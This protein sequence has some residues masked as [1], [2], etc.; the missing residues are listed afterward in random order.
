MSVIIC[1]GILFLAS[2]QHNMHASDQHKTGKPVGLSALSH[3]GKLLPMRRFQNAG[4]PDI[5]LRML[6]GA[7]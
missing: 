1:V 5:H 6:R 4:L 7:F 2:S 3:L